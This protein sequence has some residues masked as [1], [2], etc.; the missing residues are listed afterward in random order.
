MQFFKVVIYLISFG[1]FGDF[2]TARKLA[3]KSFLFGFHYKMYCRFRCSDIPLTCVIPETT[4]FPHDIYGCFF[5]INTRL[6]EN[7]TILHHVTIGSN[8]EKKYTDP[9][10]WGAPIIGNNVFIGAGAKV[11]GRIAVGDFCKIGAGCVVVKDIPEAST[12]VLSNSR[13]IIKCCS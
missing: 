3:K 7:C 9:A 13:I 10:N 5:S 8:I 12:C 2:F 4:I 11:I 1:F 6:G